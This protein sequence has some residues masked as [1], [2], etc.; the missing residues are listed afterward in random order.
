MSKLNKNTLIPIAVREVVCC[1]KN[2]RSWFL[3]SF[4]FKK[5]LNIKYIIKKIN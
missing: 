3:L 1:D 2:C 4:D 5:I